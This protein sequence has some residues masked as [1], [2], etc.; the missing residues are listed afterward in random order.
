MRFNYFFWL[1]PQIYDLHSLQNTVRFNEALL[2]SPMRE[3]GMSE[4]LFFD[5]PDLIFVHATFPYFTGAEWNALYHL[6]AIS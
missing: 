1:Q 2:R 4:S 6:T 5:A 3:F